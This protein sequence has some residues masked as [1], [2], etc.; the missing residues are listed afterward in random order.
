MKGTVS[1]SYKPLSCCVVFFF[2]YVFVLSTGDPNNKEKHFTDQEVC[3]PFLLG[4][5]INDLFINTVKLYLSTLN[6]LLFPCHFKFL[7][8]T[9][10]NH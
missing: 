2:V 9:V 1:N 6:C 4:I 10:S 7:M 3:R 8:R 5:C